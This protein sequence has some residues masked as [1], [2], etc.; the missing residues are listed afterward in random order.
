MGRQSVRLDVN[1]AG[2]M[3]VLPDEHK[4]MPTKAFL[5]DYVYSIKIP[6]SLQF[7]SGY[8]AHF[9]F[10]WRCSLWM[11]C[12]Y[13]TAAPCR[14]QWPSS[15]PVME[16]PHLR[17]ARQVFFLSE[18]EQIEPRAHLEFVFLVWT[19]HEIIICDCCVTTGSKSFGNVCQSYV[20]GSCCSWNSTWLWN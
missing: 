20:P 18:E 3:C 9:C 10:R 14:K 16:L 4:L 5:C 11:T 1:R 7:F 13:V 19:R 2:T 15:A 8:S 12:A 17:C 6:R